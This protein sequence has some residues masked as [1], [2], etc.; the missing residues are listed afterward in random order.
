M[1]TIRADSPLFGG[2]LV[3]PNLTRYQAVAVK[4]AGW[5]LDASYLPSEMGL[6]VCKLGTCKIQVIA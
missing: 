6:A 5:A 1:S 3:F 2:S 4:C